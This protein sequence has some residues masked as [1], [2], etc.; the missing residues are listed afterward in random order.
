M[1]EASA[2]P[3]DVLIVDDTVEN[4]QMLTNMLKEKGYSARPLP[5][6]KLA[7]QAIESLPP[8]LILLDINMPEMNGFEVCQRL[9]AREETRD[10]PVIFI[11]ALSDTMDKVKAFQAGGVDY[12]TKPFQIEEVHAR[13][14]AHLALRQLRVELEQRNDQLEQSLDR[15]K[16]LEQLKERLVQMIVHDLKNPLAA[17]MGNTDYLMDEVPA[18]GDAE[19]AMHDVA[20][21]ARAMHRMVINILDV[22]QLEDRKLTP[23]RRPVDLAALAQGAAGTLRAVAELGGHTIEVQAPA[24]LPEVQLDPDLVQR[25]LENLLENALKYTPPGSSVTVVVGLSPE[26]D[27]AIDVLDQGPGV[28]EHLREQVFEVYERLER[29]QDRDARKSRGLG[30][31]F[32]KLAAEAH[33]GRIWIE[34]RAPKGAAF[35]VMLPAEGPGGD[36][37]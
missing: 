3:A 30:L 26:G 24:G 36:G 6:G 11:S 32:C 23:R 16:E 27:A 14:E 8:D 31:A 15:Q 34:D 22:L 21:S 12:V 10:I 13:V 1:T 9:K 20:D 19:E 5:S 33:G 28:P 29:D 18:G 17:I 35:R 25:V 2:R 4:L 7:L 37:G